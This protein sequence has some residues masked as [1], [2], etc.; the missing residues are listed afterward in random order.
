MYKYSDLKD[1]IVLI[2][3]ASND[4][5]RAICQRY[6]EQQAIVYALHESD[7]E[8]LQM[9]KAEHPQAHNLHIVHCDLANPQAVA[10]FITRLTNEAG[11]VDVLVNNADV[12]N[13]NLFAC[14]SFDDFSSV[15]DSNIFNTFRLTKAVLALLRSTDNASIINVA[16]IA[17]IAPAMGQINYSAAKGAL[18]AFTRT[19]AAELAP[20]GI[21]VNAVAPGM[22]ESAN[23]H[24]LPPALLREMADA[25][26]LQRMGSC[27]EVAN[28]IVFLSSSAA[29][30]IVGQT[31][32]IDGGQV[33]R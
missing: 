33:M 9:L 25:I 6:L 3:G 23:T 24:M 1:K 8:Q 10:A 5:G 20:Q 14:M 26:P 29:S 16:S 15:I 11:K 19:L 32:V 31:I 2:S 18:L 27:S 30:F 13:D 17:A 7:P 28:T 4:C 22:I 21:R 12:V